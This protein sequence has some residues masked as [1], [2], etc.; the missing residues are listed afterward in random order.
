[1]QFKNIRNAW[2][3]LCNRNGETAKP[4]PP[5]KNTPTTYSLLVHSEEKGRTLFE[6]AIVALIVLSTAFT[7]WQFASSSIVLPGM[8]ETKPAPATPI[9][10]KAAPQPVIADRS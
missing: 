5:M 4:I 10:A 8:A 7:G 1:M 2:H 3:A 6:S 9:V